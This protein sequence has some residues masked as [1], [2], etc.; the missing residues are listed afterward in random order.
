MSQ[1]NKQWSQRRYFQRLG[2]LAGITRFVRGALMFT[3]TRHPALKKETV[4]RLSEATHQLELACMQA[5]RELRI[6]WANEA[7][8]KD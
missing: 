3:Q 5:E 7:D 4:A 2:A 8:R 1:S 6:H